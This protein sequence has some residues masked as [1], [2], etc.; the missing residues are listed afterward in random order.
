ML[1]QRL[2]ARLAEARHRVQRPGPQPLGPLASLVGDGE[3]VRLVPHPLQQVQALAGTREDQRVLLVGE[4]H[5]LQ[6]LG[7]PAD[8][9][10][11]DAQLVQRPP[12]RRHLRTPAVDHHQLRRVREAPRPAVLL[13]HGGRHLA[14]DRALGPLA[15]ALLL[16]QVA[17]EPAEDDLVHGADVVLPLEPLDL[18]AP[19]LALALQ[20]VL[21]DDHGR[22]HVLALQV[23]DV[24]ALDAQRRAVQS[25][26]L[27]DLLQGPGA[28]GQ[29]GGAL[30]LVQRER[31]LGVARHRLH[32]GL[33][34]TPLRHP[35]RGV[36]AAALGQPVL[37]RLQR[38]G[39]GG[40]QHLAGDRVAGLLA[41]QLLQGVL[42]EVAGGDG[43]HLVGDP[44]ALAADAAAADVEDLDGGLQLVLG[45]RHQ[46]G[47]GG[48]GE[49]HRALL[50]GLAQRADVVAQPGGALVLHVLGGD[51]HLLLEAADVGAGAAAHEVAELLGE[52]A[53]V[54]G[55]DPADAGR[56]ALVDVAEQAGPPGAGG[57]LVDAGGAG[58]D[59]EDAQQQVHGVADRPGVAV[60]AEVAHA[61]LLGAAHHLDAGDLL[62]HRHREV[63]VALV[64][65]VLDVE[66]GV[67][68]LDPGV[69]QLERLDLGGDHRPFHG[70]GRGDHGP[71]PG[72]QVGEVLEVAG[73]PLAQALRLADVDHPAVLVAEAVHPG[74]V[75]NLPRP[76]AV[77][78]GVGH[79]PNPTGGQC[80][81]AWAVT[82]LPFSTFT[83]T[84][85]SGTVA[86][87]LTT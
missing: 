14:A 2:L 39:Q 12:R 49:H 26:R 36:G 59:R 86:G 50:H 69:L 5:L 48:V 67:E 61:L 30:G 57:V 45:D 31:L 84:S 8:G 58:A 33:L 35:Q 43:L 71:G 22:D 44:A 68:L 7:E 4:P 60:G 56:R 23:G 54:L 16:G 78:G 72:V 20:T 65:A 15:G 11:V 74:G 52:V 42:D 28:G 13:R 75:R 47:V 81:D 64:V 83:G 24:V 3:P 21:E 85:V 41:V 79:A 87:G 51:R 38:L 46:V 62:V 66:P 63:G 1:E 27:G 76:G 17:P 55:G 73:Q 34:V 40:D 77:A 70:R 29:V 80:Q 10:V 6:P 53:V 9:H 32:Q 37:H 82:I 18:E 25:E 19:V